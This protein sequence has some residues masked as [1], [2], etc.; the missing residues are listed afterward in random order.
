LLLQRA[1][2]II[3]FS[4][5]ENIYIEDIVGNRIQKFKKVSSR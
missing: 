4:G 5:I 3:P 2:N 1:L